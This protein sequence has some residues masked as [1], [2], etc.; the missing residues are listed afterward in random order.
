MNFNES[1]NKEFY[2]SLEEAFKREP[3]KKKLWE[4]LSDY[5]DSF[6]QNLF[7]EYDITDIYVINDIFEKNGLHDKVS[8]LI[9][10]TLFDFDQLYEDKYSV[11]DNTSKV[12]Y[13]ISTPEYVYSINDDMKVDLSINKKWK[14]KM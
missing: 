14:L 10:T 11:F 4:S 3:H 6:V 7:D 1:L 9:E 8:I 5:F 13:F 12:K 2:Y